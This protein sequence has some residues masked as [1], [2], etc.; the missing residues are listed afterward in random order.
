MTQAL[1]LSA[2]P[3]VTACCATATSSASTDA[4]SR[5]F[6]V[7][8]SCYI[9]PTIVGT[10]GYLAIWLSGYLALVL[11]S[12]TRSRLRLRRQFLHGTHPVMPPSGRVGDTMAPPAM[13]ESRWGQPQVPVF[14]VVV[15]LRA[16]QSHGGEPRYWSPS[17][18]RIMMWISL[19]LIR[20][21]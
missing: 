21:A 10:S 2:W 9:S 19:F 8:R 18:L 6:V 3:P 13:P 14:R 17:A 11:W 7:I 15:L 5:R 1:M 20:L 12:L 16:G 4:E